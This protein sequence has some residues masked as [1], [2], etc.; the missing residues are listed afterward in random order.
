MIRLRERVALVVIGVVLA[1]SGAAAAQ[2]KKFKEGERVLA[3]WKADKDWFYVGTVREFK[4]G[5]YQV[6]FDDGDKDWVDAANVYAEDIA[7]GDKVAGNF[8]RLGLYYLGKITKRTGD[9]V[10]VKY[11]DGD[12]EDTTIAM[13]R[14]KRPR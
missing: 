7:V 6:V 14:V 4:D 9:Q 3:L 5:K 12:E 11:D 8:K 10:H 2:E 1:C 13:L